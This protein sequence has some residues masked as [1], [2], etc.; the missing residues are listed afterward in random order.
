MIAKQTAQLA[1]EA[2][3][4]SGADFAEV[5][6]EDTTGNRI[7]M[8]DGSVESA[9]S[10]RSC[11]VGVRVLKNDRSVYA[12]TAGLKEEDILRTAKQA[13]AAL[14]GN[15]G[16]QVLPLGEGA[17]SV[18]MEVPYGT[19]E[20]AARVALIREASRVAKDA[21]TEVSNVYASYLD[22][23]RRVTIANSEGLFVTDE[24]PRTRSLIRVVAAADGIAQTGYEAPGC[25]LGFEAYRTVIDLNA[26]AKEAAA[27]A[28]TMLHAPDCPAGRVPVVI[29]G[30]FGGVLFHESC[31]H[32]LEATSV[33]RGNSE[34][35]GRIGQQIAASCVTALDDGT[36]PGEWGTIGYDD[37]GEPGQRKV[38]IENGI[39]KG[40][41][42][43]RLG[44][45][46]MGMPSTGSARRQDYT[47]AA[48]SRMTNTFIAP[49]SDD[50]EEMIRTMGEG[51]Y[52]RRM[53]GGSVNPATGE[54]N[55]SVG[56]GYWVRD[57]KILC[58][59]RGATLIGKGAEVLM[60]IDRVGPRM[61]MAP[62]MCGSRSG[63]VPTNVG[64][65][66]IRITGITVG[67]RGGKLE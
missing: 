54:F 39:L 17:R 67:G 61:W 50:E 30:G 41:M 15:G 25:C 48:T 24:R 44:S 65:P 3:L 56:E 62:G 23:V 4:Q 59:V 2:A 10:T 26:A 34:F 52:A 6:A 40:Y 22:E 8:T 20:N 32:S 16:A 47:Y 1:L 14:E 29:D 38:L 42:I 36:M 18:P 21:S 5:F 33:A 51:L 63:S 64:Q 31:G 43:D 60:N 19:V 66:R 55:F 12:Y 49:G 53:G 58:P 27:T 35:A 9:N 46:I 13:A 11:G 28:V 57:G 37:E 45:R 7:S